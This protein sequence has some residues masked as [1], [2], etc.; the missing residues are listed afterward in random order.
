M[1]TSGQ[2]YSI[3]S[4]NAIIKVVKI[5]DCKELGATTA[6]HTQIVLFI[7][8]D[9]KLQVVLFIDQHVMLPCGLYST[10]R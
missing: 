4:I 1:V 6:N 10:G 3:V 9:V 2:H 5:M 8:Q 7:D